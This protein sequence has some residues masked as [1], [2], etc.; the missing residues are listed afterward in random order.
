MEAVRSTG[1]TPTSDKNTRF[2]SR[3]GP[4]TSALRHCPA[5]LK[6]KANAR[7]NAV[8]LIGSI[9]PNALLRTYLI[10]Q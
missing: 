6:S 5:L 2:L 10:E 1:H 4:A 3:F 9:A 7:G 8:E